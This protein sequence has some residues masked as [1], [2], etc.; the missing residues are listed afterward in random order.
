MAE[1]DEMQIIATSGQWHHKYD[2]W[3]W[4]GYTHVDLA[5]KPDLVTI[6]EASMDV[7]RLIQSSDVGL[8]K[9]A[10]RNYRRKPA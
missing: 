5:D 7:W 9:N 2:V 1:A 4:P 8:R 10:R 6:L 3:F